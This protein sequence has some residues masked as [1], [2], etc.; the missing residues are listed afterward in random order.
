MTSGNSRSKRK[1]VVKLNTLA[2][3][4]PIRFR[5]RGSTDFTGRKSIVVDSAGIRLE[6]SDVDSKFH[7]R[8]VGVTSDYDWMPLFGSYVRDRG[9]QEYRAR[10]NQTRSQIE[11]RVSS[12]ATETLDQ[13]TREAVENAREQLYDRYAERLDKYGIKLAPVEMRTTSER[14]VAAC[15]SPVIS[16]SART[17]RVRGLYRIVLP[18]YKFTSRR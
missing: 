12:Q 15:G 5:S 4:G 8:L 9:L 16:S 3:G 6:P 17:R 10:Q 18:A 13:R 1:G 2:D 11:H 7:N 14:V